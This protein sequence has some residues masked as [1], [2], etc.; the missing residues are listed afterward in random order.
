LWDGYPISP[1]HALLVP[2]RHIDTWFDASANE[3]LG[4]FQGIDTARAAIRER[5]RPDGFNVGMN[6]GAAA[7]QTV[8]HLHLHVIPRYAGDVEDPRGGVRWVVPER[9]AYWFKK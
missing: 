4:L 5:H 7:G 3:R 2:R 8:P 1:G 9:A 6:I